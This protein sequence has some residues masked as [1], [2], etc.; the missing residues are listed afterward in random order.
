MNATDPDVIG[1]LMCDW[2]DSFYR[3]ELPGYQSLFST[4][5]LKAMADF[6]ILMVRLDRPW[7]K[8]DQWETIRAAAQAL[9]SECGWKERAEMT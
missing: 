2:C 7:E 5:E 9:L 3:P 4:S 8:L 6:N 1:E